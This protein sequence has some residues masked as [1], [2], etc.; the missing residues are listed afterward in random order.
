LQGLSGK[1]E[2]MGEDREEDFK[3]KLLKLGIEVR[4]EGHD[5][6]FI[7]PDGSS[8]RILENLGYLYIEEG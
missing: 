5:L 4:A 2:G 1:E 6:V 8:Y 7:L 3:E